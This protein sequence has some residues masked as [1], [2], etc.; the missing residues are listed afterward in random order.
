MYYILSLISIEH[1]QNQIVILFFLNNCFLSFKNEYSEEL[2]ENYHEKFTSECLT[3][4]QYRE[5]S[6]KRNNCRQKYFQVSRKKRKNLK[7]FFKYKIS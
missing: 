7:L 3:V 4:N 6:A 2:I 5:I 1:F